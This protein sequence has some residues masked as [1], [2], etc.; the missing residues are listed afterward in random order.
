MTL[1]SKEQILKANDR[2]TVDVYVPEWSGTVR[3]RSLTAKERD[4]YE[5]S[6]HEM[7]NGVAVPKIEN[8]RAR[9]VALSAVDEDG[10]CMF[11]SASDLLD[12]S[13]KAAT[14]INRLF[15]AAAK[16]SGLRPEDIKELEQ[17]FDDAQSEPSCSDSH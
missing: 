15:Y 11:K 9:L 3:L 6:C 2:K 1:L 12:L 14:P 7:K 5:A 4:D 10:N 16:L 8:V 17:G 13:G